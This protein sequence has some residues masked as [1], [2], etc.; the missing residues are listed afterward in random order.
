[1]MSLFLLS[2]VVVSRMTKIAKKSGHSK[3]V[4]PLNDRSARL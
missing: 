3:E 4:G 1:L 2:R